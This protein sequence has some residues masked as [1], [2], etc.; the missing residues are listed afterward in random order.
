MIFDLRRT[1]SLL[2]IA[3]GALFALLGI[4]AIFADRPIDNAEAQTWIT[5]IG[6]MVGVVGLSMI[7]WGLHVRSS[8]SQSGSWSL[9]LTYL[10]LLAPIV[11]LLVFVGNESM[12]IIAEDLRGRD[13]RRKLTGLF[14]LVAFMLGPIILLFRRPLPAIRPDNNPS[15]GVR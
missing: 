2:L 13:F 10:V 1:V 8:R 9:W 7:A 3:F 4:I 5:A 11:G 15:G 14:T 12:E 6:M